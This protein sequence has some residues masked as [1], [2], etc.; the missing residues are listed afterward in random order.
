MK[1]GHV[2]HFGS[3]RVA[4]AQPS[5]RALEKRSV[6]TTVA[7]SQNGTMIVRLRSA[8]PAQPAL[9]V[10]AWWLP[11]SKGMPLTPDRPLKIDANFRSVL[12]SEQQPAHEDTQRCKQIAEKF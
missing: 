6:Q 9:L 2:R 8:Q 10:C 1:A 5:A 11:L 4:E 12:L 7:F 3:E